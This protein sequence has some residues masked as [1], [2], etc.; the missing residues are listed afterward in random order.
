MKRILF[1]VV[2]LSAS[3][4]AQNG[5]V[6]PPPDIAGSG[7]SIAEAPARAQAQ[8]AQTATIRQQTELLKQ[9]TEALKLQ[10]ALMEQQQK[11]ALLAS[12]APQ[13]F[14]PAVRKPRIDDID[15]GTGKPRF[16]SYADY[17][18]AKDEWL[19]EEAIRRFEALE[20]AKVKQH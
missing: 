7:Q 12:Q 20:A 16:A 10:N 19:I 1:A 5:G 13:Q 18:D 17:E 3:A 6:V 15:A 9:Q 14:I 8:A 4:W 2:I 11:A